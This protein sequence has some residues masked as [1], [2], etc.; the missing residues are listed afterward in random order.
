MKTLDFR[1]YWLS[2]VLAQITGVAAGLA[3]PLVVFRHT[4]DMVATGI[5]STASGIASMAG[6]IVG[7]TIADK[8]ARK[9]VIIGSN[10]LAGLLAFGLAWT[11][12]PGNFSVGLFGTLLCAFMFCYSIGQACA[13]P[14]LPQL[15][16][17]EDIA[18]AQ[19]FIQAR[20]QF[21]GL[22]GPLLGGVL[23][24]VGEW[25]PFAAAGT[26]CLVAGACFIFVRADL[27]PESRATENFFAATAQGFVIVGANPVLRSL[28]TMQVFANAALSGA[29]FLAVVSL[30]NAGF[31]G[32]VIG[33]ARSAI[34][35]IG[36]LGALA[37]RFIQRTLAFRTLMLVNTGFLAA[38]LAC[39]ALVHDSLAVVVP[40]GIA[41]LFAPAAGAVI[42]AKLVEL[43]DEHAFGRVTNIQSTTVTTLSGVWN[44]PLGYI[45]SAWSFLA[46]FW[47][48]AGLAV[49]GFATTFLFN[50]A[51]ARSETR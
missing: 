48:C 20:M 41:V 6:A 24:D 37:T 10:L 1:L 46:G 8:Y 30:E 11:A 16:S 39:A 29:L 22:I 13:D 12:L 17:E 49:L 14:S 4:Q 26:G 33:I 45:T 3:V 44:T 27:N 15:V 50:S 36:I 19:G 40:L 47:A 31:P 5:V 23:I 25:V 2:D 35:V 43:I 28:I 51:V 32:V 18:A 9:P 42:Y 38:A 34:G 21:A 7:G